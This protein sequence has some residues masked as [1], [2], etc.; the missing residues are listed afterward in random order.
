VSL[1]RAAAVEA[2]N[3][4]GSEVEERRP[5]KGRVFISLGQKDGTD[6]A[7]LRAVVATLAPDLDVLAVEVGQN[8]SFLDVNPDAVEPAVAALNGKEY[9]GKPLTV[10]KARR[11]R[12]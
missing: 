12:R 1:E 2:A 9:E 11:R 5:Q 10:E 7:K 6:E 8:H 3:G 4:A